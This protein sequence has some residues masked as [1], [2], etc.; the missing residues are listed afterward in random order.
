MCI[1]SVTMFS[2]YNLFCCFR[3]KSL[4]ILS[5]IEKVFYLRQRVDVLLFVFE[6]PFRERSCSGSY[7]I[8]TEL[9]YDEKINSQDVFMCHFIPPK[10]THKYMLGR[11]KT[12]FVP[13]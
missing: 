13:F 7:G 4:L 2:N 11:R 12:T 6:T 3:K 9:S 1:Y 10:N 5:E 8:N